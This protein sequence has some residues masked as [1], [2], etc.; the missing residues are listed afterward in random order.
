M[1]L[2]SP[3][4]LI[5]LSV[6]WHMLLVIL[7][8]QQQVFLLFRG[9]LTSFGLYSDVSN[10]KLIDQNHRQQLQLVLA[11][12]VAIL[13]SSFSSLNNIPHKTTKETV[14]QV[15]QTEKSEE[16]L[17]S[18]ELKTSS[19]KS[20]WTASQVIKTNGSVPMIEYSPWEQSKMSC[21]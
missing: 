6:L 10:P 7:L 19:S 11:Y 8:S 20:R 21:S 1:V 13:S 4:K 5:L 12:A 3:S 16:T 17:L 15:K 2:T 9:T 18:W 14:L